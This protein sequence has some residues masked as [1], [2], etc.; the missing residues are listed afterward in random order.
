MAATL[1]PIASFARIK[2]I[3]ACKDGG[4]AAT[5]GITAFDAAE[6]TIEIGGVG[7]AEAKSAGS[8]SYDHFAA[9]IPPTSTQ[10]ETYNTICAPLVAKWLAGFDAVIIM[11]G[12]TGSAP[13]SL[14]P[15]SCSRARPKAQPDQREARTPR[16]GETP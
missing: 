5:I 16:G 12:Q 14:A 2:P 3:D 11:Y 7:S 9:I 4:A 1:S 8:K 6:G 10:A 15:R 13:P